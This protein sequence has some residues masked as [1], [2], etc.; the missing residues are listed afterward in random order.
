[1]AGFLFWRCLKRISLFQQVSYVFFALGALSA[2]RN[3]PLWLITTLPLIPQFISFFSREAATY[4]LGSRRF[5]LAYK[6]LSGVLSIFVV[7][8]IGVIFYLTS[9]GTEQAFYPVQA[10]M[11]LQNHPPKEHI[12]SLQE[13]N[14][15]LVW[16]LPG[17]RVFL[18]G[19]MPSWRDHY[20]V[21]ESPYAFREYREILLGRIP[22]AK[23]IRAYTIDTVLL[24]ANAPR[25][26]GFPG[27]IIAQ[28]ERAGWKRVFSDQMAV[29]YQK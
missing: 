29:I 18:H 6:V 21:H 27:L 17:E 15:Y 7:I 2:V 9:F 4:P 16:K 14:G 13:W 8:Y 5:G 10:V 12:F 11:Y 26:K 22:F 20:V 23:T 25:T 19:M 3:I 28:L 1:M 24:P